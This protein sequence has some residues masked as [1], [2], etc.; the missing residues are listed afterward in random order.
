MPRCLANWMK[1]SALVGFAVLLASCKPSG[2]LDA[3]PQGALGQVAA[4]VS[5]ELLQNRGQ[6]VLLVGAGDQ[7]TVTGTGVAVA[8]FQEHLKKTGVQVQAIEIL[9]VEDGMLLSGMEPVS[10]A[11]FLEIYGK[12]PAADALVSFVG[13]PRFDAQQFAQLPNPRPKFIA[14]VTFSPPSRAMFASGLL[15]VAIVTR[16]DAPPAPS[17]ASARE[18]FDACYQL[19][20]AEDAGNLPW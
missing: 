13:A 16:G 3:G 9:P 15:H 14:A 5:A 20:R 4:E 1:W 17:S 8:A 18:Q 19:I 12:H 10:A 7:K 11:Q 6:V 2:K